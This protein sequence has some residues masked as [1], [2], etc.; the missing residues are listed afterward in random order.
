MAEITAAAVKALRDKTGAG[1]M[2]CKSALVEAAGDEEKAIV[3]LRKRGIMK[4]ESKQSRVAAEGLVESYIHAGGR[5][6][7]LIEVNSE[8]DFVARNDE[9]QKLVRDLAMQV[10]GMAP[11]GGGEVFAAND[12]F[13]EAGHAGG[14]RGEVAGVHGEVARA[15]AAEGGIDVRGAHEMEEGDGGGVIGA[16]DHRVERIADGEGAVGREGEGGE[17]AEVLGG[18]LAGD[19]DAIVEADVASAD[20]PLDFVEHGELEGA[21]GVELAVRVELEAAAVA[22]A[23]DDDAVALRVVAERGEDGACEGVVGE[24]GG[25]DGGGEGGRLARAADGDNS[26][27]GA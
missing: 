21:G 5:L 9:F 8:T 27:P 2:E 15:D 17:G 26:R 11:G 23:A 18:V 19:R 10:A 16:R 4:A 14:G 6:G 13:H 7:V 24:G 25:A 12:G 3:I 1:M 22:Q 20:A